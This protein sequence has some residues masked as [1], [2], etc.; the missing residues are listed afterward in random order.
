M[1]IQRQTSTELVLQDGSRWLALP[2]YL[3]GLALAASFLKDFD[4]VGLLAGAMFLFVAAFFT[5]HT[6][7]IFD[8]TQRIVRWR[9]RT[10]VKNESGYIPFDTIRGIAIDAQRG[11]R[12]GTSY[13]LSVLTDDGS[14][15][16][17]NSV[18]GGNIEEYQ[19]LRLEILGFIGLDPALSVPKLDRRLDDSNPEASSWPGLPAI[20]SDLQ[21]SLRALLAQ[22]RTIDAIKLLQAREDFGLAETKS[23]I[24][25]LA[26]AMKRDSSSTTELRR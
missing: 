1:H 23:R 18:G 24:E 12:G 10:F 17:S 4:P 15:P 22:G 11:A 5:R 21:P 16:M 3:V 6:A 14:T 8:R 13:R 20:P 7:F 26:N 2:F 19:K 9:R 25:A